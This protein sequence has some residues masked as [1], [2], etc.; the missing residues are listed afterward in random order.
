MRERTVTNG[1]VGFQSTF[2]PSGAGPRSCNA[3]VSNMDPEPAEVFSDGSEEGLH[4]EVQDNKGFELRMSE[5]G[6]YM[7]HTHNKKRKFSSIV[8]DRDDRDTNVT[9]KSNTISEANNLPCQ[10]P[11]ISIDCQSP[12]FNPSY[13]DPPPVSTYFRE[14]DVS[15]E[16][17]IGLSNKLL[18]WPSKIFSLPV[19]SNYQETGEINNDDLSTTRTM[20]YSRWVNDVGSPAD[21][22]ELS[23]KE[24]MPKCKMRFFFDS[25]EAKGPRKSS[26]PELWEMKRES[27]D[28]TVGMSSVSDRQV[29]S[30]GRNS[31]HD[32]IDKNYDIEVYDD[33]IRNYDGI[34]VNPSETESEDDH[35]SGGTPEPAPQRSFNMLQGCRNVDEFER[36]IKIDEGTYGVVFRAR[37]KKSEEVVTLKKVKM[38]KKREGFP[39]TSLREINILLSCHHPFIVDVK[40]VVVGTNLDSIFMVMEYREHDLKGLIETMK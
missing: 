38:E 17:P 30:C 24:Y 37:D 3:V 18:D 36:L 13:G 6:N 39:L 29:R 9:V 19:W 7:S 12:T 22:G 16:S 20:I 10:P 28:G 32:T 14:F 1:H 2:G 21:E 5:N 25:A 11:L 26:S 34:G 31:S 8:W 15:E 40:E 33:P 27:T 4:F 35:G 23:D